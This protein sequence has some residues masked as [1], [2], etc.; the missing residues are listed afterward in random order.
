MNRRR[1]SIAV[2]AVAGVTAL[3]GVISF[4]V[5]APAP[6]SVAPMVV[7]PVPDLA[8]FQS[9]APSVPADRIADLV[10]RLPSGTTLDK[11]QATKSVPLGAGAG[12]DVVSTDTAACIAVTSADGSGGSGCTTK[13]AVVD[14]SKPPILIDHLPKDQFR[15]TILAGPGITTLSVTQADGT[16]TETKVVD[17]VASTVVDTQ[18]T[19]VSWDG[20]GAGSVS[21]AS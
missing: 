17:N 6:K 21:P 13:E 7:K 8:V 14:P 10:R 11:I 9:D 12:A 18:P 20:P 5:A 2:A 19:K 15:V 3:G 4:A 16:T 1:T